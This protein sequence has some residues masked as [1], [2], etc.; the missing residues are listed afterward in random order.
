LIDWLVLVLEMRFAEV[1][2][3]LI[4]ALRPLTDR[5]VIETNDG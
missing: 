1:S 3:S 4:E 5:T 2:P